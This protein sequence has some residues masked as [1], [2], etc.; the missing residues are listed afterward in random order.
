VTLVVVLL[1]I[2]NQSEQ[3]KIEALVNEVTQTSENMQAERA[4]NQQP[5]LPAVN[6]SPQAAP[7]RATPQLEAQQIHTKP[8]ETV[9][10]VADPLDAYSQI[11]GDKPEAADLR[12]TIPLQRKPMQNEDLNVQST[13]PDPMEAFLETFEDDR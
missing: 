11:F 7:P 13:E 4:N 2:P 8:V 6:F 9:T 3:Q 12:S 10:Q 5:N 1:L